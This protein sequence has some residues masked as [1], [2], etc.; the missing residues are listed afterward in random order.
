MVDIRSI[1]SALPLAAPTAAPVSTPITG[2]GQALTDAIGRLDGLQK[3][4]ETQG[5]QL[6]AGQQ[7]DLHDVMIAQDRASLSLDLAVQ[8]RNKLVESYQEIMRMQ[9]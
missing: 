1:Q 5:L 6:A 9:V 4:A 8:V 7:V 3:E 2:F